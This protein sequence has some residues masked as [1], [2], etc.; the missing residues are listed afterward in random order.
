MNLYRILSQSLGIDRM[1]TF[2]KDNFVSTGHPGTGDLENVGKDEIRDR[3]A[4]AT[5]YVGQELANRA[6]E[7]AAFVHTMQDGDYILVADQDSVYLGDVGDYYYVEAS[8]SEEDGLCHRRGVTWL[9]RIPR[10]QLNAYVQ[11]WLDSE[12]GAVKAFE[13]SFRLAGLDN[14]VSPRDQPQ[15]VQFGEMPATPSA[16][17]VDQ[18]TIDEAL[19]VLKQALRCEDA[20]RR[21][22]AAAAILRYAK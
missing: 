19:G 16:V 22:R 18:E 17:Y 14:W 10:S 9:N 15:N 3:L 12:G 2:L 8:D 21:E 7:M 6:E 4:A 1:K 13:Y 11:E 5:D 20:D